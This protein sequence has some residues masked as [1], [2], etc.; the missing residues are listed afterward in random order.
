MNTLQIKVLG[1]GCRNCQ[2]LE[3]LAA[4]S[5]VSLQTEYPDLKATLEHIENPLEIQK[6]PILF[7]PGL[8]VNE[9]LVSSGRI[10]TKI[11]VMEWLREALNQTS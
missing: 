4:V 6:Y 7:T 5:L 3:Q 2:F 9:K 8:V 11:Q 10:P 1:P